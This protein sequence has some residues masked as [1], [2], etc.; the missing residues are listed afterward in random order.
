MQ[1][2][3]LKFSVG[4]AVA[5]TEVPELT[6]TLLLFIGLEVQVSNPFEPSATPLIV[7]VAWLVEAGGVNE[8]EEELYVPIAGELAGASNEYGVQS[9][10]LG[11]VVPDAVVKSGG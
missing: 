3:K 11:Q 6:V 2:V 10:P 8:I 5:S 4:S 9:V 1:P 7:Y